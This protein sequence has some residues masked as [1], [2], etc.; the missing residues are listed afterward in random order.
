MSTFEQIRQ[1]VQSPT[2]PSSETPDQEQAE[3][4]EQARKELDQLLDQLMN[5]PY[6]SDTALGSESAQ[7]S[8][9]P[10]KQVNSDESAKSKE[11]I[12]G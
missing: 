3:Q 10:P 8:A 9:Q 2:T 4:T 5:L 12:C 1:R 11:D 7:E 6:A